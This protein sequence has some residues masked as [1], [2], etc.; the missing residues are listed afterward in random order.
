[1][2]VSRSLIIKIMTAAL[3]RSNYE[4]TFVFVIVSF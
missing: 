2:Y 4:N 1:M 3:T